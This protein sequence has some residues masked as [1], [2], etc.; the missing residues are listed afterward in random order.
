MPNIGSPLTGG[1]YAWQYADHGQGGLHSVATD[2]AMLATPSYL[3]EEGMLFYVSA[4]T[5]NEGLP[6][7]Y[8]LKAGYHNPLV[9]GDFA[10]W[11]TS[12]VNP[13]WATQTAWF[14]DPVSGNDLN[15]GLTSGTGLKTWAEFRR[16]MLAVGGHA[17]ASKVIITLMSSL[18]NTDVLLVDWA[19]HSTSLLNYGVLLQGVTS[20]VR[21]GSIT[22]YTPRNISINQPNVITDT[23]IAN[24]VSDLGVTTGH[25]VHFTSGAAMGCYAWIVKDLGSNS[26]RLSSV[27]NAQPEENDGPEIQP[28]VGDTYEIL[29]LPFVENY[30]FNPGI[31]DNWDIMFLNLGDV[32]Y[33]VGWLG[34]QNYNVYSQCAY[35]P[36]YFNGGEFSFENCCCKASLSSNNA[37]SIWIDGGVVGDLFGQSGEIEDF[38][39]ISIVGGTIFQGVGLTVIDGGYV[40]ADDV[41]VFDAPAG[42]VGVRDARIRGND[43]M[44][45]SGNAA[46]GFSVGQGVKAELIYAQ[47]SITGATGDVYF[48]G[49]TFSWAQ[50]TANIKTS[51]IT[52]DSTISP[53]ADTAGLYQKQALTGDLGGTLAA[54]T[55]VG[56]H[57]S[58][59]TAINHKLTSVTDPTNL[60]DAAT[61]SYVDAIKA[62]FDFKNSVV[63]ATTGAL[64]AL[65]YNG[66]LGVGATL[67][68][69]GTLAAFQIDGQSPAATSRVLIKN[70]ASSFQNGVYTVTVVGDGATAWVLTRAT[71]YDTIAKIQPGD[72]IPVELG[73]ANAKTMWLETATVVTM[74]ADAIT[75]T[76]FSYGPSAFDPAGAAATAQ[77]NAESYADTYKL[78]KA[79]NLSD[80]AVAATALNNLLPTQTAQTGKVLQT[81]GTNAT[82]Q[83]KTAS[84]TRMI[85]L[86]GAGGWPTTTSGCTGPTQTESATNKINLLGLVFANG[87]NSNA[88]WS[89]VMPSNWDAGTITATYYWMANSTSTNNVTFGCQAGAYGDSVTLDAALGSAV[90][91][92]QA[93]TSTALQL[94]VS[95][96]SGAITVGGTPAVNN[97]VQI[98]VYR[99]GAS[100]TLAVPATLLAVKLTY[101]TT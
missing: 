43:G 8:Y 64:T 65:Y 26:A 56:L 93:N 34:G 19:S 74:G 97:M 2:A 30:F 52:T 71:D 82:W 5:N 61:K 15:T 4:S 57:L 88:Q 39:D 98:Q 70:Q 73:T 75:F 35:I 27:F 25:L 77:S 86:T 10:V 95:S 101:T 89:V 28:A 84:T 14:I 29:L 38:S 9:I 81:D 1:A 87:V 80:V 23:G 72:L 45:G 44:W 76:Q 37:S 49:A 85:I 66:T 60:Q 36:A 31:G 59:D 16:R 53:N 41:G 63:A 79:S 33:K 18:P 47:Q 20:T 11:G 68:N 46:A 58:A 94:H 90:E 96:A 100:D 51:S 54:P 62:G 42:G 32:G 40:R 83:S 78:A 99:K 69:N 22:G 55:V 50:I 67:T 6:T 13:A 21:T 92:T 3:L 24:W 12:G 17:A 91:V 7:Y 48:C